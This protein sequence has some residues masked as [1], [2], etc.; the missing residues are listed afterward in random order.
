MIVISIATIFYVVVALVALLICLFI[1][2]NI[3]L[4]FRK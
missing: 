1:S 2:A 4:T 3:G